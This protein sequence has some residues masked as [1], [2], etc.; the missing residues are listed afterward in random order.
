[1]DGARGEVPWRKAQPKCSLA[2]IRKATAAALKFLYGLLVVSHQIINLPRQIILARPILRH[3]GDV[4]SISTASVL[5][6]TPVA[7]SNSTRVIDKSTAG[8]G[9]GA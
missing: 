8:A 1:M 4:Y 3:R 7:L 9:A 2:L 5:I 6:K